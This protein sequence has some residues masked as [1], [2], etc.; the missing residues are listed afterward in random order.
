MRRVKQICAK[1]NGALK[2]Q[3]RPVTVVV[4]STKNTETFFG[5]TFK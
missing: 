5:M 1:L 3:T 4:E 2:M